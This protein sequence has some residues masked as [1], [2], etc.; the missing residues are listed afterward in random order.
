[1]VWS[2]FSHLQQTAASGVAG[3]NGTL[4]ATLANFTLSS[5]GSLSINAV[6]NNTFANFT[7]SSQGSLSINAVL[8]ATIAPVTLVATGT[9]PSPV[10]GVLNAT[11]AAVTLNAT[12]TV[13]QAQAQGSGNIGAWKHWRR[14][15][16]KHNRLLVKAQEEL[17]ASIAALVRGDKPKAQKHIDTAIEA[18]EEVEEVVEAAPLVKEFASVKPTIRSI[19]AMDRKLQHFMDELYDEDATALL[20]LAA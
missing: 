15:E 18:V 13:T 4:T 16:E 5:Q 8:G 17:R 11:I 1:M 7:L 14:D 3:V 19:E 12:G 2:Y 9:L 6:V 10:N 20:L